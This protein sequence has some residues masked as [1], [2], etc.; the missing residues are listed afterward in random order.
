VKQSPGA[1]N[2]ALALFAEDVNLVESPFEARGHE[3][4][5]RTQAPETK[6][7]TM[8]SQPANSDLSWESVETREDRRYGLFSVHILKNRSP[9]TGRV[10]EFQVLDSPDW[11]AVVAVTPSNDLVMVRQYRHGT[12]QLS[13]EPPGGLVKHGQ[14]PEQSGREELEEETGYQASELELL[15]WMHPMPA[16]FTNKFYVFL[17][18]DAT[19]SGRLNPDETEEIETVLVP[20][21]QLNEYIKSGKITCAVMIAALHLYMEKK[22][23]TR[24]IGPNPGA[25]RSQ[26]PPGN[27]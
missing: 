5:V 2:A 19:P 7:V 18:R 3:S 8:D 21:S 22:A 6:E 24:A 11:V 10:H 4:R 15:G 9:R 17:A 23:E 20:T 26:A 16:I 25:S 27:A 13:L 12:G 14:S 1:S